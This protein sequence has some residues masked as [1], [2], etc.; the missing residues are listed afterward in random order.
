MDHEGRGV[1]RVDGKAV[2]VEGALPGETVDFTVYRQ[3]PTFDLAEVTRVL[4]LSA[5]RVTPRCP[6]FG[7]CGGC[8][9]QHLDPVAQTAVKQRVLENAF[10]HIGKIRPEIIY[11]AIHGP[12]WGYRFRAR[13][14]VR[15]VPSKGGILVGF[16]ERRSSYIADMQSCEVQASRKSSSPAWDS[17]KRRSARKLS[18]KPAALRS[19]RRNSSPAG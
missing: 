11:P 4:K 12:S 14:G 15:N 6:H 9:I 10:R 2:F 16:R 3:R 5:Q 17:L 1:A 7:V 19:R 18:G 8:S 13:I